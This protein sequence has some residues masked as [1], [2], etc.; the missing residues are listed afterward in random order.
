MA[1]EKDVR[2][3]RLVTIVT[4]ADPRRLLHPPR[5][6]IPK[7]GVRYQQNVE[8]LTNDGYRTGASQRCMLA[9]SIGSIRIIDY[10]DSLSRGVRDAA[11]ARYWSRAS[12]RRKCAKSKRCCLWSSQHSRV[13]ATLT[14]LG[15]GAEGYVADLS[16][17][18]AVVALFGKMGSF[19]PVP[20]PP[21][22]FFSYRQ[23]RDERRNSNSAEGTH[24]PDH[25]DRTWRAAPT[26]QPF[27]ARRGS[28]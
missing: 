2:L 18:P 25:R 6:I 28:G 16:I 15:E 11:N 13:D 1:P 27:F 8:G 17:E 20:I 23:V 12:R 10:L 3:N 5:S 24:E 14:L 9:D 19:S 7:R 4:W 26:P 22:A 21:F